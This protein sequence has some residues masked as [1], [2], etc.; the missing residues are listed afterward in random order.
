MLF[1][2][3]SMDLF[4]VVVVIIVL[5]IYFDLFSR[6][7]LLSLTEPWSCSEKSTTLLAITQESVLLN[8]YL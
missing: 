1:F 6:S 2:R 8:L 4:V 3:A 7:L 5:L